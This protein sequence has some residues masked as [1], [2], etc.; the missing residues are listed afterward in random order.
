VAF[1]YLDAVLGTLRGSSKLA[2]KTGML[3]R[4][5]VGRHVS[6]AVAS[7]SCVDVLGTAEAISCG[8]ASREDD[9]MRFR[10]HSIIFEELISRPTTCE[11]GSRTRIECDTR[12]SRIVMRQRGL[13]TAVECYW[14]DKSLLPGLFDPTNSATKHSVD[15]PQIAHPIHGQQIL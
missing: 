1:S 7:G 4:C 13:L 9:G 15:V 2:Y 10:G 14:D 5:P 12:C 6:N 8:E 11:C 3:P